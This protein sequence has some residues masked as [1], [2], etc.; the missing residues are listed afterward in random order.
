MAVHVRTQLSTQKRTQ[1]GCPEQIKS[2]GYIIVSTCPDLSR[3]QHR[4][5]GPPLAAQTWTGNGCPDIDKKCLPRERHIMAVQVRIQ[6]DAKM[7]TQI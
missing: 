7:R 5:G 2:L 4:G 6:M 3:R 1:N